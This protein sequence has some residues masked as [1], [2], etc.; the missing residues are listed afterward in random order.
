[1]GIVSE[2]KDK[3]VSASCQ[4]VQPGTTA[5]ESRIGI[6]YWGLKLSGAVTQRNHVVTLQ[7]KIVETCGVTAPA[8]RV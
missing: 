8:G 7:R 6:R 1:M 5:Q 2:E 4:G 3:R